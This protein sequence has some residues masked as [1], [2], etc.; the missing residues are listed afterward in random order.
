MTEVEDKIEQEKDEQPKRRKKRTIDEKRMSF[1]EHLEELRWTIIRSLIG[2]FIGMI[3]CFIFQKQ[4]IDFLRAPAPEDL[5]LIYLSL[6]EGFVIY[7]KVAMFGGLI[8]ALPYVVYEFWKFI[9]PGLLEKERKLVPPIAFATVLCFIAGGAFAYYIMIPFAIKFLL[10]FQTDYLSAMITIGKYLGFVVTMIL[11]F[12]VVFELPVLSFLLSKMGLLTPG[13]M[14]EYRRYAYVLIF[15]LGALVTPPDV[16][17]Q[18]ML[19]IP[20][21]V[22]YEISIFVSAI[23]VRRRPKED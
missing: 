11:A 18:L 17:S 14:R 6:P 12:G 13:F 9:V 4:V 7:I 22:L 19:A 16:M 10:S 2:V 1:W 15:I 23:V 5:K 20:L 3:I 21:I 8:I